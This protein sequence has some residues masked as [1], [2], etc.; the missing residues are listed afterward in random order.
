MITSY[1][2]NPSNRSPIEDWSL[3]AQARFETALA[4]PTGARPA[5]R[6]LHQIHPSPVVL[7]RKTSFKYP[8]SQEGTLIDSRLLP[9]DR[10]QRLRIGEM[11]LAACLTPTS[12]HLPLAFNEWMVSAIS[13]YAHASLLSI[14]RI[15]VTTD[16]H[17][18]SIPRR[19]GLWNPQP[20]MNLPPL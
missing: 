17:A 7:Y 5:H 9:M 19:N 1:R 8:N 11:K 12:K 3:A 13:N 16:A 18:E 20:D 2:L 14:V 4:A 10:W 15:E 6:S